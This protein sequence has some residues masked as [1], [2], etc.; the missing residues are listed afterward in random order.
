MKQ[1]I[2]MEKDNTNA[3]IMTSDG[4]FLSIPAKASW[5]IGETVTISD[6]DQKLNYRDDKAYNS[7]K[8]FIK[9]NKRILAVIVA[10][11]LLLIMPFSLISE[12]ST[13]ITLDINPSIEFEIKDDKVINIRALNSDGEKLISQLKANNSLNSDESTDIYLL[14]S[15]ILKEAK[16]MGYLK[17]NEDNIIMV[18]V[19]K[20]KE[21]KSSEYEQFIQSKLNED[22]I[23]SQVILLN[24]TNDEKKL[25]DEKGISLGRQLLLEKEKSEGII[26][27][28][29][30]ITN[31]SIKNIIKTIEEEK[32]KNNSNKPND[33]TNEDVGKPDNFDDK[34]KGKVDNDS[35]QD[36]NDEKKN[37]L[38]QEDKQNNEEKK[39]KTESKKELTKA[40]EEENK[41][42]NDEQ[43]KLED[44]E[45]QILQEENNREDD[46]SK[47]GEENNQSNQNE[48]KQDFEEEEN[49]S[50]TEREE[51][52]QDNIEDKDEIEN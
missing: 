21:F 43:E 47:Q 2:I 17:T 23:D 40:Q 5:K 14:T 42:E 28:D 11:L 13:Y 39:K 37:G 36:K 4:Q 38:K 8:N 6:F 3:V 46:Q 30:E 16:N 52:V 34:E 35:S 49:K 25:A 33:K 7:K 18:G 32:R 20:N 22:N 29:E 48:D 51:N 45:K 1:G 27:S 10:S 19:S 31:E 44:K 41:N 9:K 12:A 26:I 50:D 15:L 24:G